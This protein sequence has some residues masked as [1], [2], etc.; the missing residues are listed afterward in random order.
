MGT[1]IASEC[2]LTLSI[3]MNGKS[4]CLGNVLLIA[5]VYRIKLWFQAEV[6]SI[7]FQ[8]NPFN[9]RMHKQEHVSTRFCFLLV[10]CSSTG[11][12]CPGCPSGS[13]TELDL[14]MFLI[15][16][17]SWEAKEQNTS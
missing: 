11:I 4:C 16:E 5:I 14:L 12:G 1:G 2:I 3:T 8:D 7:V 15:R 13:S 9:K 10:K 17:G 6:S